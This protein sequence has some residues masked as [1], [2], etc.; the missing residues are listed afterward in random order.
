MSLFKTIR[1]AALLLI[2]VV[3][4]GNHWLGMARLAA[5]D[6]PIWITVY[7]MSAD[8]K[9][10]TARYI[11]GLDAAQFAEIGTYFSREAKRFGL[12]IPRAAHFQLAAPP[13]TLPPALPDGSSRIGIGWWSL[14]MRWWAWRQS[15]QDGLLTPDIQVFMLYRSAE[16]APQLDR[17]VGLQKGRYTLVNAYA[18]P[19]MAARNRVVIAHEL[20]HVLGATDKYDPATGRPVPPDGLADPTARP[21]YPQRRAEIMAGAV[22]LGPTEARMPAAL[23]ATVVGPAT[24]REIGWLE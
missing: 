2:L 20:L 23:G 3:V 7:P 18:S 4:A 13:A 19:R 16:G 15:G 21:L 1:V 12:D 5:W 14:K 8:G 9:D 6:R 10:T 24:A 11:A 22:A 17:S